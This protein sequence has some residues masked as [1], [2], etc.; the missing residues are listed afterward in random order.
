LLA[1]L[2]VYVATAWSGYALRH[3]DRAQG[4][5]VAYLFSP[6]TGEER[7]WCVVASAAAGISEEISWRGVQT[8]LLASLIGDYW[9]GAA[10]S[11]VLFALVHVSQG[12][13][14]T[15]QIVFV[16]LGLQFIVWTSGTLYLAM[17]VHAAVNVTALYILRR[18]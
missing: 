12:W 5:L 4:S 17:A 9:I 15:V 7:A 3:H 11:A 13:R 14:S 8:A 2:A 1:S 18:P 6:E 16:A 10:L